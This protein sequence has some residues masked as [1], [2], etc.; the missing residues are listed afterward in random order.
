ML[1]DGIG[2]AVGNN[3][4]AITFLSNSHRQRPGQLPTES[5]AA[6]T[7]SSPSPRPSRY[8]SH[9]S[10]FLPAHSN[11]APTPRELPRPTSAITSQSTSALRG[12]RAPQ[13]AGSASQAPRNSLSGGVRLP[14]ALG[15]NDEGQSMRPS[16]LFTA[17]VGADEPS[18]LLRARNTTLAAHRRPPPKARAPSSTHRTRAAHFDSSDEEQ[19]A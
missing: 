13:P 6:S 15:P 5:D 7:V 1:G 14:P 2:Y 12:A 8:F 16:S 10:H 18:A 9:L 17:L 19:S 4:A 3:R 11:S